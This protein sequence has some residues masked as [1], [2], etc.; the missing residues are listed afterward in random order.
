V[1]RTTNRAAVLHRGPLVKPFPR[2]AIAGAAF[3]VANVLTFGEGAAAVK[4]ATTGAVKLGEA[5][6]VG[7]AAQKGV[8][9]WWVGSEG[10]AAAANSEGTMLAP[11]QGATRAA[12]TGNI[13]PIAA[14]SAAAAKAATGP[15]KVYIGEG[16]GNVFYKKELPNLLENMD[17]GKV[18]SIEINF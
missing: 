5:A 11:S 16:S 14:E 3:G 1:C 7:G 13:K 4:F 8:N 12:A 6:G 15:Q 9:T 2:A 17:K 18:P 10:R